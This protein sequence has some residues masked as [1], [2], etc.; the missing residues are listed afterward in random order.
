M[1]TLFETLMIGML[2][3][4][5][6]TTNAFSGGDVDRTKRPMPK[7]A[8][9]VALPDIQKTTLKNGLK[10]WLVEHHELPTVAFNLVV[11]AGSDHDPITQPGIAS[12]TADV[13]DEGTKTRDALKISEEIESIGA[14]FSTGSSWDGSFITMGTL[15]KHID[16][17]LSVFTDVLTH[18]TFPEKDFE[19]LRKQRLTT[20][21]QQRDQPPVIAN[22]AYSHI[23]YG[24]NHPY[25]NNP[26][27]TEFALKAMTTADLVK[28]YETYYRPNNATLIIVG[29][30][31]LNDITAKIEAALAD[32]KQANVPTLSLPEPSPVEKMQVYLID[33]SGAPQSEVR[34]G[35][36]ALA[37]ST[38]DYFP[39]V[40]M[41][42]MLGGQFTS[43]I[44]LNLRERHGYTYGA[45]SGFSFQKGPGPFTAQGGIVTEKTDS[46]LHEFLSEIDLMREKGMSAD[47]LEYVKK[48][49][50]GNFALTFETPAQIAGALQNI[51]L[52]G[53]PE[54]YYQQYLQNID[55]V[56][57]GDVDRVAKKYLDTSKMAIVI[58]GDLAKIK[59][60]VS[61]MK[62]G[63]VALCDVDGKPLP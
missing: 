9:K 37:R 4:S 40:V 59:E 7:P 36:P 58:V 39:V 10:V 27:G 46:A 53:L 52:Y 41:N 18:P 33:K 48:G 34:I 2:L 32:W 1:K 50:I 15:T 28:F 61:G 63:P 30:V 44:N 49:L 5:V 8:P 29:D 38:P 11:Q 26:S 20:L 54:N 55:A 16:K 31:K 22:N 45:R 42:R 60:S 47:E 14:T 23:L 35:Y 13:I 62:L 51:V 25:G 3:T 56:S 12:M 19:R 43:R 21:L 57:L 17:A 6:L 24:S